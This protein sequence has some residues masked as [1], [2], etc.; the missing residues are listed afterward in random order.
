MA[1]SGTTIWE[2][3]ATGSTVNGGGYDPSIGTNDYSQQ[4]SAQYSPTGMSGAAGN[5]VT[6]SSASADMVGNVIQ[7]TGGTNFT[8]DFFLITSVVVG[9]SFTCSTNSSG[10]AVIAGGTGSSGTGNIGG[11]YNFG[12]ATVDPLFTK[13]PQAG[14]TVWIKSGSYA[15]GNAALGSSGAGTSTAPVTFSGYTSSRGD[16]CTGS[17]RPTIAQQA[18]NWTFTTSSIVQNLIITGSGT[19]NITASG[20]NSKFINLLCINTSTTANRAAISVSGANSL[21]LNC[22]FICYRGNALSANSSNGQI[23]VMG[24]YCHDSATGIL[25]GDS[26]S[27]MTIQDS[28]I[29]DNVSNAII[30]NSAETGFLMI[31]NC[32]LYGAENKLGTGVSLT[33]G[34][35]NIRLLDS[36]IY[37]FAT[38]VSHADSGQLASY[39]DYNNYYN[40]TTDNTN[41]TKGAHDIALNPQFVNVAQLTGSSG[42]V[43]GSTLT[44]SSATGV[45]ANQDFVYIVSGT[46]ATAG[47]Y[48]ITNVA[49]TTLTLSSAPG[50]SGSNIVYQITTGHNFQ[51]GNNMRN[52]GFP[53]TFPGG[54]TVGQQNIGAVQSIPTLASTFCS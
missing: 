20:A 4:N 26:T 21:L 39:D 25:I 24:C 27:P 33:T 1:V 44:V 46:G 12:S 13:A 5:V 49:G 18:V 15:A 32:T 30:N 23:N 48:L 36:I 28:I 34:S 16:V 51:V 22:E 38:G 35:T 7:I 17:N 3:R 41:W 52:Q 42:V 11:A 2:V 53:G 43:S 31:T 8:K 40:N 54:L 29:A 6:Y 47:K 19:N 9:V 10:V 14:N 50:G 37:G 45:V